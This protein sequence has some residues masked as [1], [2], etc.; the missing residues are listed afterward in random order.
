[1]GALLV[2]ALVALTL[3]PAMCRV[4]LKKDKAHG[5]GKLSQLAEKGYTAMFRGY[6][7]TLGIALRNRRTTLIIVFIV[8]AITGA[9]YWAI[10]KGFYPQ[11]DTGI[12]YGSTESSPD[13]S[14]AEMGRLQLSAVDRIRDDPAVADI[15]S[16]INGDGGTGRMVIAL[17]PFHK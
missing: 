4:F 3:T 6:E 14:V 5:D 10:P 8:A 11:Q 1:S 15:Y 13:V 9:L 16:W 12:I 17:K 7:R 2:S